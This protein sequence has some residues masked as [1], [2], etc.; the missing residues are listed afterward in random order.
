[1]H[2]LNKD[3]ERQKDEVTSLH[4]KLK[5]FQNKHNA[6][7]D[8]HKVTPFSLNLYSEQISKQLNVECVVPL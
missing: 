5:L 4:N 8:A 2:K 6:E 7:M 1:M 3:V